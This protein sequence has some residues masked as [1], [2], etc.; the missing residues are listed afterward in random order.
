MWPSI[1]AMALALDC[2]PVELREA[3]DAGKLPDARLDQALVLYSR[4]VGG[5]GMTYSSL[6]KARKEIASRKQMAVEKKDRGQV[7]ADFYAACGGEAAV[8]RATGL[9]E[10][11]LYINKNRGYLPRAR[12]FEFEHIANLHKQKLD[13]AIFDRIE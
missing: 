2:S 3:R 5:R 10:T 12:R 1:E 4:S 7:I 13:P 8:A 6:S 11:S 9:S